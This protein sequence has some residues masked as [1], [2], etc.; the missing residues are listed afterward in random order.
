MLSSDD[1]MRVYLTLCIVD[2]IGR[3]PFAEQHPTKRARRQ[4][5][6]ALTRKTHTMESARLP[7]LDPFL[8]ADM[9]A[10]SAFTPVMARSAEINS[11]TLAPPT[12]DQCLHQ[13][14]QT[15]N[16]LNAMGM[17]GFPGSIPNQH[18]FLFNNQDPAFPF[19]PLLQHPQHLFVLLL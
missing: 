3:S 5:A 8:T 10:S 11:N 18:Q 13:S 12:G 17:F 16:T 1:R 14:T 7:R 9:H 4:Y 6:R 19:M 2:I 15:A